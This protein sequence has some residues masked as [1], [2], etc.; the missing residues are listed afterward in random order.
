MRKILALMKEYRCAELSHRGAPNTRL[1]EVGDMF[2]YLDAELSGFR[3]TSTGN[4][5]EEVMTSADFTYAIQTFVQRRLDPAYKAKRF[6]FEQFVAMDTTPNYLPVQRYQ[7]KAQYDDLE[8]VSEK[9]EARPGSVVDATPRQF[10]VY[11]FKKQ[12][13][14][15]FHAL[16]NDDLGYFD[17]A[18]IEMGKSARRTLERFVSR[19]YT[20]ATSITRLN[21]LGL[22]YGITGR[23]TSSR[24]SEARMAFNQRTDDRGNPKQAT[25]RYIVHHPGLVDTVRV[26]RQSQLVPELATNAANVI[27]GDFIPI[28]DP[29]LTAT[30]PNLP[31]WAFTDYRADNMKPV[32]LARWQGM[33]QPI[34]ARKKSDVESFSSFSGAGGAVPPIIG[35]FQTNNIVVMVWDIWGTYIDGT[36]GSLYDYRGAFYSAGTAP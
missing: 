19:M 21:N 20:N 14:F 4:K 30:A 35:D 22:L 9:G 17:D 13:D 3:P 29:Y 24:I 18:A 7:R 33:S 10:Q 34:L 32:M 36:E 11:D 25:L 8:Y 1:E 26:I 2:R 5:M 6:D 16:V 27:A 15:S 31:W 12:F 28:E 23:L